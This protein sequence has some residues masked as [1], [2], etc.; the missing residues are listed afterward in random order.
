MT[1]P[2]GT[3]CVATQTITVN[4]IP[5]VN[6]GADISVCS[7]STATLTATGATT[8]AWDYNIQNG[9]AFTPTAT[10]TYTVT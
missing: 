5:N 4:P 8:Y 2:S 6:A 3:S 1:D 9:V 10:T 7:G